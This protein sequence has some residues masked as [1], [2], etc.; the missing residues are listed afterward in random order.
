MLMTKQESNYCMLFKI[1]ALSNF[2]CA[3][4]YS[5]IHHGL[6]YKKDLHVKIIFKIKREF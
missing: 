1:H 6:F 5:L 4:F 2:L 3:S